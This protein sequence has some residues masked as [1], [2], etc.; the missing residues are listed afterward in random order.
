MSNPVRVTKTQSDIS[1]I[2]VQ[3][4]NPRN[5]YLS[6]GEVLQAVGVSEPTAGIGIN[7]VTNT[8]TQ[9]LFYVGS[10]IVKGIYNIDV[11]V[12]TNG[13]RQVVRSFQMEIVEHRWL[14]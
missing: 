3:F 9:V 1:L 6:S 11:A 10:G 2:G 12:V 14:I 5:M 13:G 7:S 8:G 4:A